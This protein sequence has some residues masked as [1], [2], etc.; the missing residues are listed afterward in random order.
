MSNEFRLGGDLAV[1]RLGF[2]TMRLPSKT[3][4]SGRT[5]VGPQPY[6]Q[7]RCWSRGG[8]WRKGMMGN[9]PG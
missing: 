9:P 3:N 7:K 1:N 8:R 4:G 5:A 2:G 6:C